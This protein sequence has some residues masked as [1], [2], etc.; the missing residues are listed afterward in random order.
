M[1]VIA[2]DHPPRPAGAGD[3]NLVDDEAADEL[4]AQNRAF[5][6]TI[7]RAREDKAQARFSRHALRRV[8]RPPV[9][10]ALQRP[11]YQGRL[12]TL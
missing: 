11:P 12:G 3:W 5:L 10:Q 8:S 6:D 1:A 4:I 9:R 7:R 2:M